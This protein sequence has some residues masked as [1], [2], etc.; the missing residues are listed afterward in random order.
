MLSQYWESTVFLSTLKEQSIFNVS[1]DIESILNS[2]YWYCLEGTISIN[3]RK[4]DLILNFYE[5]FWI[6]I[7]NIE[8]YWKTNVNIGFLVYCNIL[9]QY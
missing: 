3:S 5:N 6:S 1:P 8:N 7:K 2:E 4:N 9:N